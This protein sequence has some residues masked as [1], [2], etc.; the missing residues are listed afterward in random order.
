MKGGTYMADTQK[1]R[2]AIEHFKFSSRPSNGDKSSPCT[3]GDIEKV[4]N[5]ISKVL[6][7]F[8]EE[9]EE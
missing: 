2:K 1:L 5:N 9:L 6:Q 3:V 7:K 8:V 4:V